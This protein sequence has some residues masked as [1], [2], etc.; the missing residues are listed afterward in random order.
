MKR[1]PGD[2][3][4]ALRTILD[5]M[6]R[7]DALRKPATGEMLTATPYDFPTDVPT[8]H[9]I[10][11]STVLNEPIRG[12]L[13]NAVRLLGEHLFEKHGDTDEMEAVM[14]RIADSHPKNGGRYASIMDHAWDEIGDW[15][16]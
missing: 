16:C 5:E 4:Q 15:H 11:I 2:V 7:L 1:K 12:A 8:R 6:I 13:R 9:D 14:N 3:E 10:L